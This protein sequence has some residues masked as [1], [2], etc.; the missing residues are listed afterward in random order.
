[1]PVITLAQRCGLAALLD[2]R[3]TIAAQGGA[4]AAAKIL[5]VAAGMVCG[6]DSITAG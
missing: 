1:M 2:D 5:A 3:L 6:A 4:N